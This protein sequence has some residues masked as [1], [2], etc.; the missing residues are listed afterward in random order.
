MSIVNQYSPSIEALVRA[1]GQSP[2]G[3]AVLAWEGEILYANPAWMEMHGYSA[4]ESIG[5]RIQDLYPGEAL[6]RHAEETI[7][8]LAVQ[9]SYQIEL[10]HFKRDGSPFQAWLI[11]TLLRDERGK[12]N[13]FVLTA[14]DVT[15]WN[16][17]KEALEAEK[18]RLEQQYQRQQA[19][20][21]IEL[22]INEPDE[23]VIAL[24]R[25][26]EIVTEFLPASG[27]ASILLWDAANQTY[28]VSA[29]SVPGQTPSIAARRIR[30]K[31]GGH[32]LDYRQSDACGRPRCQRRLV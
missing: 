14:R 4:E 9:D 28:T 10:S 17:L 25:I 8:H 7:R 11:T 3:V 30:E 23:L 18:I 22:A 12:P 32:P 6:A 13:G 20:A 26:V 24:D 27:G 15:E 31:G 1:V 16:R 5:R 19:L 29:S 21:N 2:D